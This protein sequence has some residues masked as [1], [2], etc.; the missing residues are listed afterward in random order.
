MDILLWEQTEVSRAAPKQKHQ[1]PNSHPITFLTGE[2][3]IHN[4][5]L[6]GLWSSYAAPQENVRFLHPHTDAAPPAVSEPL[7]CISGMGTRHQL[8]GD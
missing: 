5:P 1:Q 6:F 7:V 8:M 2:K 3:K 4:Q